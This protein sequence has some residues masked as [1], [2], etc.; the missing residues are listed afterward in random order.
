MEL[1]SGTPWY[2][3][4]HF[5][6]D[7]SGNRLTIRNIVSIEMAFSVSGDRLELVTGSGQSQYMR[8]Q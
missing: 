7:V 8:E 1:L 6:Y 5:V 4:G 3:H 2:S